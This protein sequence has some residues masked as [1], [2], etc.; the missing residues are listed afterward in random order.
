MFLFAAKLIVGSRALMMNSKLETDPHILAGK[1]KALALSVGFDLVGIAPAGPSKY[2][3]FLRDWLDSKKHGDMKFLEARFDERVDVGTLLPGAKS[4][5]CVAV[6]YNV[7][8]FDGPEVNDLGKVAKYARGPDYH[9]WLKPRLYDIGDFLR[10]SVPGSATKCG[11]DTVPVLEREL[12]ARAGIGYVGKNTCVIHPEVGSW[13][14]LGE[15]ITTIELPTD[16]PMLDRCGTCTRCLDACPTQALSPYAIDAS[17]CISYLT[18]ETDSP[19]DPAFSKQSGQWLFGCDICQDVC[20]HNRRAL[21]SDDPR[22]AAKMG[23]GFSLDD[24]LSWDEKTYHDATRHMP[25]RRVKLQQWKAS[26]QRAKD[27]YG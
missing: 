19:V 5:V 25:L 7:A 12:A 13:I 3:E 18:I 22:V 1:V 9:T 11:V 26:A 16:T 10:A 21:V 15:V 23:E 6:N 4:V 2:R 8:S 24:V 14:F 17:K 27:N 20:P